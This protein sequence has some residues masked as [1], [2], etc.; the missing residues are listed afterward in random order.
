M[1][2]LESWNEREL[3]AWLAD[4]RG[5]EGRINIEPERKRATIPDEEVEIIP[6]P[7]SGPNVAILQTGREVRQI[8]GERL[9]AGLNA[10]MPGS[11]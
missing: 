2:N 4:Q 10:W 3:I 8:D 9:I 5:I 11:D 1:T 7:N 6:D